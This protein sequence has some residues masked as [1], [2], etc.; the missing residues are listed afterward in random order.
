MKNL[1][2]TLKKLYIRIV[3]SIGFFPA[4]IS[5]LFFVAAFIVLYIDQ[6]ALGTSFK[7]DIVPWIV[8]K[9]TDTARDVLTTIIAGSVSLL[10]LSF[11]MVMVVLSQ[12]ASTYSPKVISGIISSKANQTVL[13]VYI[14]TVIYDLIILMTIRSYEASPLIPSLS[15]F[16]GMLAG[17]TCII[18]FVYF[19]HSVSQSIQVHNIIIDIH[20]TTASTLRRETGPEG[21]ALLAERERDRIERT[22]DRWYSYPSDVTGYLQGFSSR[23]LVSNANLH[24]VVIRLEQPLGAHVVAGMPLFSLNRPLTDPAAL[25][26]L[27]GTF[28]FYP[29]EPL[30]ENGIYGFRQLMEVAVKALSP[31]IN[32]PGTAIT[33]IDYLTSLFNLRMRHTERLLYFDDHGT[34]RIILAAWRFETLFDICFIPIR[35]YGRNDLSILRRLLHSLYQLSMADRRDRV[36][37]AVLNAGARSVIEVAAGSSLITADKARLNMDIAL[38]NAQDGYFG[39]EPLHL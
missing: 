25:S 9:S 24:D 19:I 1:P 7:Q 36:Y 31:G 27:S 5:V 6:T 32:D 35:H 22:V 23:S 4:L 13:G 11:S 37:Q 33:C 16:L 21:N 10:V 12:A 15:I 34:A 14:G 28:I 18:L 17:I 3:N 8:L 39:L 30:R 2:E 20:D 29:G 38:L 26:R